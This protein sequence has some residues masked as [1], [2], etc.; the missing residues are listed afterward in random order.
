MQKCKKKL[1]EENMNAMRSFLMLIGRLC[2]C[3]IFLLAGAGK[4]MDYD[5]TAQYMSA[6]GFTMIPFFLYG[7]ALIEIVG[8]L[9]VFLGYKT[10]VGA[11]L[12]LL[13]LIPTTY[14]FHD[15]WNNTDATAKTLNMIMFLKNLGI[16]GGLL[17]VFS[18]GPGAFSLDRFSKNYKE[19]H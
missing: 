11:I 19:K 18:N 4:L 15:F 17:Y 16:F 9:S 7:A 5:G 10:R 12:L 1:L 14:I 6:K 8:G 13:F 2:I 3:A